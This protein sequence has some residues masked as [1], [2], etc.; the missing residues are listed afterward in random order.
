MHSTHQY[1]IKFNMTKDAFHI[2]NS[3][4]YAFIDQSISLCGFSAEMVTYCQRCAKN[5]RNLES[6]DNHVIHCKVYQTLFPDYLPNH[7]KAPMPFLIHERVT[8]FDLDKDEVDNMYHSAL[9]V[10]KFI[11]SGAFKTLRASIT[12]K[13]S[14]PLHDGYL[15]A[16]FSSTEDGVLF[17]KWI[18]RHQAATVSI[19]DLGALHT[20]LFLMLVYFLLFLDIVLHWMNKYNSWWSKQLISSFSL[21]DGE[22]Y[23]L[24]CRIQGG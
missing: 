7:R 9:S 10:E 6:E 8:D 3:Q 2:Y 18:S 20:D 21:R 22:S 11:S 5:S 24:H 13:N 16:E 14:V 17:S 23:W 1:L 19:H 15:F 12:S 4:T